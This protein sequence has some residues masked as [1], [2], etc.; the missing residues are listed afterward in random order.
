MLWHKHL[1]AGSIAPLQ[2]KSDPIVKII[3]E[4][5]ATWWASDDKLK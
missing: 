5:L 2:L 3:F 1:H 4:A